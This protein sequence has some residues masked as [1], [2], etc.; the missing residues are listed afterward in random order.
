MNKVFVFCEGPTDQVIYATVKESLSQVQVPA[1]KPI[2]FGG[3][4]NFHPRILETVAPELTAGEPGSY[5]SILVFRDRDAGEEPS[6]IQD[7]FA[8]IARE[9]LRQWQLQP[10][11][12]PVQSWP[13]LFRLDEPPTLERPGLC[14][15]LHIAA[16]P[17]LENLS[18][19]NLTTDGYVLAL[20]LQDEVL[21][22]FAVESKVKSSSDVLRKLIT[23]EV[24]EAISNGG[25]VF[26]EDKDYLAAYLCAARFWTV[27]RAEE[28]ERLLHVILDRA[29]RYT[30][31]AFRCVLN[32]WG[33]AMKEV[34]R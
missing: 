27:R 25:I 29:L 13:N 32:S 14:L 24:P 20:A 19:K 10:A 2:S 31:E 23:H 11:F 15:V 28:K 18:L 34:M 6:A 33:A 22:R 8:G 1:E 17:Q 26:D 21:E 30:P 3:K 5:T 7:A 9:L 12:A 4:S 16:P